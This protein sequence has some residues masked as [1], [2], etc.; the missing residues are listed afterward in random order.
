MESVSTIVPI[1]IDSIHHIIPTNLDADFFAKMFPE[2]EITEE[3]GLRKVVKEQIELRHVKDTDT[4]YRY[5]IMDTLLE[6]IS[7]SLPDSFIKKYLV[8]NKEEYT[9]ENIEE[10]YN[11]IKKAI[12][13]QLIEDQLAKDGNIEVTQDEMLDYADNYIRQIY[14]STTQILDSEQEERVKQLSSEMI[15]NKENVKNVYE[16][17]FFDKLIGSLTEKLNPKIKEL[18]FKDFVDELSGKK[19]QKAKSKKS[20]GNNLS[21]TE[22]TTKTSV[23]KT[24]KVTTGEKEKKQK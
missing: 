15:K 13:Y 8:E 2:G 20:I 7:F 11:D 1:K 3:I 4:V 23:K 16:N 22:K 24:K 6:H 12:S 9:T 21:I 17:I 5:K 10:K 18:F 19:E 14:F